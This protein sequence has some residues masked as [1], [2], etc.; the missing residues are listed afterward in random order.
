M[1]G[2]RWTIS[3]DFLLFVVYNKVDSYFVM[4][5]ACFMDTDVLTGQLFT[6]YGCS[7]NQCGDDGRLRLRIPANIGIL[8]G[9]LVRDQACSHGRF[10]AQF[11]IETVVGE[12]CP[13]LDY[14]L[15]FSTSLKDLVES[16]SS[17]NNVRKSLRSLHPKWRETA[18]EESKDLSSLSLNEL[19]GKE[20]GE[21]LIDSINHGP[22]QFKVITVPATEEW[23]RF[24][25]T[26]KQAKDLHK[27]NLDQ[28]YA[29][30]KQNENDANEVRAM[31]HIYPNPLALLA[32]THNPPPS[33][34]TVQNVQG[35]KS[36]GY[37]VNTGKGKATGTW[38]INIVR[39]LHTTSIFKAD[40]V[41]AFDS[42]CD[43]ALTASAIFMARLSPA[44]SIN[45]DVV[46]P[47]YDSYILSRVPHYDT[48]H[49]TNMLNPIVQEMEYYEHFVSN[50][51]SNDELTSNSNDISYVEYMVTIENDAAQ[52]VPPPEQDNAMILSILNKCKVKAVHRDYL[53]VTKERVET[54]QELLEHARALNSTVENL[55]YAFIKNGNAPS[56]TKVV[57]GV[58]TTIAPATVEEKDKEDEKSLLQ[59][60]EKR[61]GGNAAT[62]KT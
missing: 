31:R 36:Q 33:Y 1:S 29:Y 41:E 44:R 30:L 60:V 13:K 7:Q 26:A 23:S 15:Y 46:G 57:E 37:M 54:L 48:H 51:D 4:A 18:I 22:F 32:N 47:T 56:I 25:T 2:F 55:D 11:V 62:K 19:I 20:N 24:V 9:Q 38:V 49:E 21:M 61:F 28:L 5:R 35:R 8:A 50:N 34:N 27:V 43:K 10:D 40:H 39:D 14:T 58:E 16:F 12:R 3:S 42:D 59:A 6:N 17:K 53:K 52:S 45:G